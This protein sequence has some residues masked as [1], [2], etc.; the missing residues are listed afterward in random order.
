[1]KSAKKFIS[2]ISAALIAVS[3]AIPFG[4]VAESWRDKDPNMDG[5]LEI[6]D[7][8]LILQC[9]MGV[10][11]PVDMNQLDITCNGIVSQADV[12]FIFILDS[13]REIPIHVEH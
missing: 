7:G 4:A 11:Q 10:Y 3:A 6:A 5:T 9:L 2:F 12:D 1:M 13:R 8:V